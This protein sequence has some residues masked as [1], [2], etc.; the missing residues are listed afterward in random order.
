M[1]SMKNPLRRRILRELKSDFGKYL[2][3]FILLATSI[4]FVSGF[5]VAAG[6]M[7][8]AYNDS[9]EK[10]TIENGNFRVGEPL[11]ERQKAAIEK[12]ALLYMV[13]II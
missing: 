10:Y 2:V 4:G 8:K 12:K 11:N 6:S 1:I 5:L 3:I 13:F 9:F 7:I